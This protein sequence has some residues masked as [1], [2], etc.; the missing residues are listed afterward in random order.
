M[1]VVFRPMC[2]IVPAIS[3][4][5]TKSPCSNGLS[6]PIDNEASTSLSTVCTASAMAIPPTPRLATSA[7]IL[8][9]ML[10]RMASIIIAQTKARSRKPRITVVTGLRTCVGSRSILLSHRRI[11]PSSHSVSCA[12]RAINQPCEMA[13][14]QPV[15]KSINFTAISAEKISSSV[16]LVLR[17]ISPAMP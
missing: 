13:L 5:T 9:P 11:D 8:M 14:R 16:W 7:V 4:N 12:I 3:L 1:R 17:R 10:E 15:G 6:K 2:S